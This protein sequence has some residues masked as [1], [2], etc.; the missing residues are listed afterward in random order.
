MKTAHSAVICILAIFFS[1]C[2]TGD[3]ITSYVI[4]PDGSIS[5][6]IY[7]MN[8]NSNE[9]GEKAKE[10]LANYI[11]DLEKQSGDFFTKLAKANTKEIK[12]TILRRAAPASVLITGRIP[13]L[14]DLAAFLSGKSDEESFICTAVSRERM[15]GIHCQYTKNPSKEKANTGKSQAEKA[16]PELARTRGDSFSET[17]IAL[18]HG[19]FTKAQGFLIAR[20]KRSAL[21]AL[22]TPSGVEDLEIQS[23]AFSVEW[24]IPEAKFGILSAIP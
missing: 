14:Y 2:V 8:L 4:D 16:Q 18:S 23:A 21:F 7:R 13:S 24:E 15:R 1:A 5:F 10:E 11:R 9:T 19:S 17:R 12:V 20:D 3:E 22:D 6:T